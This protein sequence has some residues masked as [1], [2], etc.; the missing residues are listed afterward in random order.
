MLFAKV[1]LNDFEKYLSNIFKGN[2][3]IPYS[4]EGIKYIYDCLNYED[5]ES[6]TYNYNIMDQYSA[7]YIQNHYKEFYSYREVV[8]YI[9][10]NPD[11]ITWFDDLPVKAYEITDPEELKETRCKDFFNKYY[12]LLCSN[13]QEFNNGNIILIL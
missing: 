9:Y 3:K 5:P 8:D 12:Q 6:E 10:E 1:T 4:Q 2:H 7:K 13:Y 11:D